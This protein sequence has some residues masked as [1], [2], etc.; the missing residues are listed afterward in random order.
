MRLSPW[1]SDV[2]LQ[3]IQIYPPLNNHRPEKST[4]KGRSFPWIFR[5]IVH[6]FLV[7][8]PKTEKKY[9]VSRAFS[10][11][12][13]RA[14]FCSC[15]AADR[16]R[17]LQFGRWVCALALQDDA[18]PT[19]FAPLVWDAKCPW[20]LSLRIDLLPSHRRARHRV[21][22]CGILTPGALATTLRPPSDRVATPLSELLGAPMRSSHLLLQ[23][24]VRQSHDFPSLWGVL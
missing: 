18:A 13:L 12:S 15:C 4:M 9:N 5:W 3:K 2:C 10:R 14:P 11:A 20:L 21:G 1:E 23:V 6:I 17:Q 19:A 16:L 24:E 8:H 22:Y 7:D